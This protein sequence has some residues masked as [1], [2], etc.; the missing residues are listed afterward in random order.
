MSAGGAILITLVV[1]QLAHVAIGLIASRARAQLVLDYLLSAGV[2]RGDLDR[3]GI[4]AP[5]GLDIAGLTPEEISLSILSE[6][7]GVR[8]GGSGRSMMEAKGIRVPDEEDDAG[9][10]HQT[11]DSCAPARVKS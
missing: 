7:V 6:I 4:R 11:L 8:R 10:I 3:A 2:P 9:E 5:A 1:Y